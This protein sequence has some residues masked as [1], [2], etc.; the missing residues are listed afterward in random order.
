MSTTSY[1]IPLTPVK[2]HE[3]SRPFSDRRLNPGIQSNGYEQKFGLRENHRQ[4]RGVLFAKV[5]GGL[6]A[7]IGAV[8]L[9]GWSVD[10][11][12]LKVIVPG[13]SALKPNA[14]AGFLVSGVALTLLSW[15]N[16]MTLYR[17][18]ATVAALIVTLLGVL[19]LGEH[20][21]NCDL[22]IDNF[23]FSSAPPGVD[24]LHAGRMHPV[25]AFGF[26]IIG[27]ALLAE[28]LP[29]GRRFRAPF[30]A[31]LSATALLVG[32]MPL[33]G[34]LAEIIAGSRWNFMGMSLSGVVG[35]VSF[36]LMGAG[37]LA[38][39]HGSDELKWALHGVTS[40][41]FVVGILLTALT[42]GFGFN[43]ARRM[44]ETHTLVAHRQEV[45]KEIESAKNGAAELLNN[46]RL[47]VI[48]GKDNL[49]KEQPT[50]KAALAKDLADV[51]RLVADNSG[52]QRRLSELKLLMNQRMDWDEQVIATRQAK[53]SAAAAEMIA[54]G[55]GI[56][57]T[58]QIS[59]LTRQME[60][61]EYRLL[62][63]DQKALERAAVGTFLVLPMG[64]FI[65]A[66][67]LSLAIFFLNT[68][69]AE[70]ARIGQTLRE[71][72]AQ[73][74]TIVE[75]LDQGVVVSDLDGRLLHWNAAALRLHGYPTAE[76]DRRVFT[77]LTDTFTL[78]TLND[79]PVPVQDWPLARVLR[80]ETLHDVELCM[81]RIGTDWHR[82]LSFGGT[83][84]QSQDGQPLMGVMTV[85]DITD[86]KH[87]EEQLRNGEE[88]YR[89]L[90]ESNPNPMWVFD[91]E[92]CAFLAVNAAATRHYGYSDEEFLSMTI[93]DIRPSEDLPALLVDL[94][95]KAD[96]LENSSQWRHRLKDGALID[97]EITSHEV[98]WFGRRAKLVLVNDVTE[99]K[100]AEEVRARLAAIIECSEDAIISK[101]LEGRITSWNRGAKNLF[102]YSAEEAIG[103]PMLM[104]FPAERIGEESSILWRIGRG[105]RIE[106]FETVRVT[107]SGKH[108]NVSVSISPIRNA[109]GKIVGA[110]KIARDITDRKQA[111]E[112]IRQLNAEL[113]ERV[114]QRTAQLETANKE[115]EAFSYSV[116]HDLRAPLR[117]VDG[118][119]LAMLEDYGP[120]L[121]SEGRRY[122]ETIR[123]GAQR[124]GV[125]I[126]DLLS[127]S[128]LS[129]KPLAKQTVDTNQVV[130]DVLADLRD[131]QQD[132]QLELRIGDL[133]PCHG[134]PALL[135][136][137]WVN[138]V[139]NA[140]K[141]TRKR[142]T[143]KIEIGSTSENG[144][145]VYFISDNG[146]G[147]DMQYANKL[148]GV[149]QRLHRAEEFEGT[150]VGLATVQRIVHRHGGRIW[151][152]AE[153]DRGAKFCFTLQDSNTDK[154]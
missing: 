63:V 71:S 152:E 72:Q 132:R 102:G 99:R 131:Q 55:T 86:R 117:A 32:L 30:V 9:V 34:L 28:S 114:T 84:V 106:H 68:G 96:G 43:F 47:Y 88:R 33:V 27:A 73:L 95:Q 70:R 31:G 50:V 45:L 37:L 110:S 143:A 91:V 138:L 151:A 81:H 82:I 109:Q 24:G 77:K 42:T 141:Y 46:E 80:G 69:V 112:E 74:H 2:Q 119:S 126:D 13:A 3:P 41:G 87:A 111:E 116:S 48:L 148:F 36:Q 44:L 67:V 18:G 140:L 5:A 25:S 118:F 12:A 56:R 137:V 59:S 14:A 113:E 105:Q 98:R 108:I 4:R 92:T 58:D 79:T 83:L 39:L 15:R 89:Q 149:F 104:L 146:T 147:F 136:Q 128:R 122:L 97:V 101:T 22:W 90:F 134:D 40:A 61:E 66:G 64:V 7:V 23:L 51:G 11:E 76:Q 49:L 94:S 8:T 135:K 6:V 75:N 65:S 103:Q 121:P 19:T 153:L 17:V 129:R 123:N 52:Q 115:L 93:K 125:L 85:N 145:T 16:V 1:S 107:K 60:A 142:D 154:V 21:W 35:A 120:K 133:P 150:G 38:L 57:L 144:E 53:D 10:I 62:A 127:F 130:Q 139:S 29:T 78:S 100:R 20:L 54:T 124:M 26:A